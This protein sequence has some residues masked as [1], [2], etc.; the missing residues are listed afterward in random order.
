M[1][2]QTRS[3]VIY[4]QRVCLP[5]LQIEFYYFSMFVK[6]DI[7]DYALKVG[8]LFET[9]PEFYSVEIRNVKTSL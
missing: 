8:L 7:G 6:T 5:I 2:G 1:I 4:K 3:D 9:D